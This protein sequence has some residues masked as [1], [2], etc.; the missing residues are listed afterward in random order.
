MIQNADCVLD[1]LFVCFFAVLINLGFVLFA[2]VQTACTVDTTALASHTFDEVRFENTLACFEE[3]DLTSFDTVTNLCLEVEVFDALFLE[4]FHN[5]FGKTAATSKDSAVVRSVIKNAFFESG[6][7][8]VLAIKESLEFFKGDNAVE[9]RSNVFFLEFHLLRCAR[10]NEYDLSG[11][12]GFL[13]VL[14]NRACGRE[15]MGDIRSEVGECLLNVSNECRAAG[16]CKEALFYEL[17]GF[18]ER[19]HICAESRF[20]NGVEAEALDTGYDLTELRIGK[21]AGDRGSDDSVY[22]VF[23]ILFALQ[24]HIDNVKDIGLIGDRAER[25]LIYASTAGNALIVVD[26]CIFVFGMLCDRA[27]LACTFARTLEVL[28]RAVRTNLSTHTAVYALGF[29]NVSNVVFVKGDRAL[30]TYVFA[31]VSKTATAYVSY[32]VTADRTFVA[33]SGDNLDDVGVGAVAA[34]GELH[35]VVNDRSFLV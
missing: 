25:A 30:L 7:V 14:G 9:I 3:C 34:H 19:D 13:D 16:A 11:R 5:C 15:V 10:S 8:E 24:N 29:V 18:A 33:S 6:N 26:L 21:L 32:L 2:V 27:D 17:C 28:D 12:I 22:L 35:A 4:R 1:G 20:N 23:G 31:T